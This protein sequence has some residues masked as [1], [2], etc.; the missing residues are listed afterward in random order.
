MND[1]DM[2]KLVRYINN[3]D[4]TLEQ[5]NNLIRVL[6]NKHTV[7]QFTPLRRGEKPSEERLRLL[8]NMLIAGYGLTDC[9]KKT[10]LSKTTVMNHRDKLIER[11]YE[12]KVNRRNEEGQCEQGSGQ[13]NII[14]NNELYRKI[15][16]NTS[17]D[18][19][20]PF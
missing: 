1:N 5:R 13:E 14:K 7:E 15:F 18:D 2:R 17:G 4:M 19:E 8:K 9:M 12:I 11:G 16:F 3:V 6:Q 10:G 20:Y